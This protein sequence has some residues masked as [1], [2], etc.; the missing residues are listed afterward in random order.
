MLLTLEE[1]AKVMD[2]TR[3]LYG[4]DARVPNPTISLAIAILLRQIQTDLLVVSK[5]GSG[6]TALILGVTKFETH[7]VVLVIAPIHQLAKQLLDQAGAN[8]LPR[9]GGSQ[10]VTTMVY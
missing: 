2:V 7:G 10:L 8:G 6:K 1:A 5:T 9:C 3:C 4:Q